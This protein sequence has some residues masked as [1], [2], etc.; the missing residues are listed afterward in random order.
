LENIFWNR[1]IWEQ[2]CKFYV[3]ACSSKH[4]QS[5]LQIFNFIKIKLKIIQNIITSYKH[6]TPRAINCCQ[7][8][9][10]VIKFIDLQAE[11][12]STTCC[13]WVQGP[14]SNILHIINV[15]RR[16]LGLLYDSFYYWQ[17]L[18]AYMIILIFWIIFV[19]ILIKKMKICV[20]Y[21]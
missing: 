7:M 14:S 12:P 13:N 19:L 18:G 15:F 5:K 8:S 3:L 9:P 1:G 2:K 6:S 17:L 10:S 21:W 4:S 20:L 16:M 11:Q